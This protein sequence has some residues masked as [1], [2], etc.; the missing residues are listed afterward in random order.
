MVN[1]SFIIRPVS[2]FASKS[3]FSIATYMN[4]KQSCSLF[5]DA[6]KYSIVLRDMGCACEFIVNKTLFLF[7]SNLIYFDF[8]DSYCRFSVHNYKLVYF[9]RQFESILSYVIIHAL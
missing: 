6:L 5:H 2:S 8:K 3:L 7:L 9:R 4:K 1:Q